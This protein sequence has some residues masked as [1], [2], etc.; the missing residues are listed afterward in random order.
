MKQCSTLI[1]SIALSVCLL[2]GC[3][4]IGSESQT[5][6]LSI[7]LDKFEYSK[8]QDA[9]INFVLTNSSD[10]D[11]YLPRIPVTI[12][13]LQDGGWYNLG[14][15]MTTTLE[16]RPVVPLAPGAQFKFFIET[17]YSYIEIGGIYRFRFDVFEDNQFARPLPGEARVSPAFTIVQ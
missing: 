7:E 1:H 13:R 11:V 4:D 12:E 16:A 5:Y 14:S 17:V 15:W 10:I 8:S 3:A 6:R 9:R 2:F